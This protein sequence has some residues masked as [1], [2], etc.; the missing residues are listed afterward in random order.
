[1]P[2]G[3]T[4]TTLNKRQ[5]GQRVA[6]KLRMHH[7]VSK[8]SPLEVMV[9]KKKKAVTCVGAKQREGVHMADPPTNNLHEH[10]MKR[11]HVASLDGS[12]G[13]AGQFCK[14]SGATMTLDAKGPAT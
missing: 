10:Q 6:N 11:V 3:T 7:T 12:F 8:G 14:P 5:H 4:G 13:R 1:M 2:N 9:P